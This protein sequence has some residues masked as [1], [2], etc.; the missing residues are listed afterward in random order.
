MSSSGKQDNQ[1]GNENE[2]EGSDWFWR[3]FPPEFQEDV[4]FLDLI[5][6]D[7]ENTLLLGDTDGH[8]TPP[9]PGK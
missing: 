2:Q 8:E 3:L 6:Q 5:A 1:P 4:V 7:P 9:K